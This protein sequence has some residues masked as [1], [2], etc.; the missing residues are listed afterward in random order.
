MS[1]L[2]DSGLNSI[3]SIMVSGILNAWA[4]ERNPMYSVNRCLNAIDNVSDRTAK[5]ES[6][7]QSFKQIAKMIAAE[8]KGESV[9]ETEPVDPLARIT[10]FMEEQSKINK[11]ILAKL[12]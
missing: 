4:M 2:K 5:T 1:M 12:K 7:A 6:K 9:E 10:T 11:A 3:G 8:L